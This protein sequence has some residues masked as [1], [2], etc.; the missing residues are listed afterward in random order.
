VADGGR[1]EDFR[2]QAGQFAPLGIG[3][4]AADGQCLAFQTFQR[5]DLDAQLGDGTGGGRLVED[6][7]LGGSDFVVGRLV[8]IV[9]IFAV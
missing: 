8:Q 3:A 7:F 4:A 1:C 9:K 6:F 2:E 5:F